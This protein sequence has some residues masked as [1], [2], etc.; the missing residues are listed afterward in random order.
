[1]LKITVGKKEQL[2]LENIMV[3]RINNN[4]IN[5]YVITYMESTKQRILLASGMSEIVFIK[6]CLNEKLEIKRE[7]I[8]KY[9]IPEYIKLYNT[10]LGKNN[11]QACLGMLQVLEKELNFGCQ[12]NNLNLLK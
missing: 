1:M 9:M 4:G 5:N 2:N 8:S 7:N 10:Y 12:T 6:K 3:L 11:Y